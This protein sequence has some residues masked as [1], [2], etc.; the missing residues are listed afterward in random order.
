[1]SNKP[2]SGAIA[3][4]IHWLREEVKRITNVTLAQQFANDEDRA[5]WVNRVKKLTGEL[6]AL[7]EAVRP[8]RIVNGRKHQ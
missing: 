6:S 1:M 3:A 2:D 8:G 7:E 5:Y 4:R